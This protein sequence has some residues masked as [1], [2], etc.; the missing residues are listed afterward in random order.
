[1]LP[2]NLGAPTHE[3]HVIPQILRDALLAGAKQNHVMVKPEQCH[4]L[5]G[6]S[7]TDAVVQFATLRKA[8][9]IVLGV[10]QNGPV[11]S[12]LSE[13]IASSVTLFAP[14][15]VLTLASPGQHDVH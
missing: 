15:P 13:D 12:H 5:Y 7:V 14:C 3:R 4:I 10:Q 11:V 9:L 2:A 1:V 8:C 6:R